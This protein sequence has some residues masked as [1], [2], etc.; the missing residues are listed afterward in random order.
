MNV[1]DV[2]KSVMDLPLIGS[3]EVNIVTWRM[4]V[5]LFVAMGIGA[6]FLARKLSLRP[7]RF[8]A[9]LEMVVGGFYKIVEDALGSSRA[10]SYFPLIATIFLFV[11]LSNLIGIVP[12]MMSPTED[13][14][15]CLSLALVV[16]FVAHTSGI[17]KKGL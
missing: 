5:L 6:F 10:A 15:V 13:L 12:G 2:A 4:L 16:F 8:Q 11:L 1:G 7:S 14:N 3:V 17:R 9:V